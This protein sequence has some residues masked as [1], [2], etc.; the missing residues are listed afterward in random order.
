M[1]GRHVAGR[2]DTRNEDT[3]TAGQLRHSRAVCAGWVDPLFA[4]TFKNR[5]SYI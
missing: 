4:I 2:S 1:S 3:A 5:A